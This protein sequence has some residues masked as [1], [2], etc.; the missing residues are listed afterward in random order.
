MVCFCLSNFLRHFCCLWQR[1]PP[2]LQIKNAS[3]P[4]KVPPSPQSATPAFQV[5]GGGHI[6]VWMPFV[7]SK[8]NVFSENYKSIRKKCFRPISSTKKQTSEGASSSLTRLATLKKEVFLLFLLSVDRCWFRQLCERH[9]WLR[10][11]Y[12]IIDLI[13]ILVSITDIIFYMFILDDSNK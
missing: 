4:S 8:I 7:S 13:Y 1:P 5:K 9:R 3:F 6:L 11:S 2:P 10:S 12:R